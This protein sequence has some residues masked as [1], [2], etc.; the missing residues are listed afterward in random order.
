MW[1]RVL[2][3][4]FIASSKTC[5]VV[6]FYGG[7][8][9]YDPMSHLR[10]VS[11]QIHNLNKYY[12]ETD[13]VFVVAE[14]GRQTVEVKEKNSITH[15]YRPNRGISFGSWMEAYRTFRDKYDYYIFCEEDYVFIKDGFDDILRVEYEKQ[16][17]LAEIPLYVVNWAEAEEDAGC[18]LCRTSTIG[19]T[20][21]S[22]LSLIDDS[23][24]VFPSEREC[25]PQVYKRECMQCFL[26]LVKKTGLGKKNNAF[27]Y[28]ADED[29]PRD[30]GQATIVHVYGAEPEETL[31][32]ILDRSILCPYQM[33]DD[34]FDV[35]TNF[36]RHRHLQDKWRLVN[37]GI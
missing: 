17:R 13:V 20:C 15:I 28:W 6:A 16:R 4:V 8:G 2:A 3:G 36:V 10:Y 14:D 32:Q 7:D 29:Q 30:R 9:L 5:L 19:I 21:A 33:L 12:H 31:E 27:P 1:A 24:P 22:S 34:N 11:A 35:H 37:S 26:L 18:T 25:P 23:L